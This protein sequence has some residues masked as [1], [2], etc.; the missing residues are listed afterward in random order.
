MAGKAPITLRALS[1][2]TTTEL[3]AL[4]ELLAASYGAT[5]PNWDHCLRTLAPDLFGSRALYLGSYIGAQLVAFNAFLPQQ[6]HTAGGPLPAYQSSFSSTLPSHSGQGHFSAIQEEA[7]ARLRTQA[8]LIIGYP[9]VQSLPIF[10]QRLG[11]GQQP[12][13]Y[14][15]WLWRRHPTARPLVPP[16]AALVTADQEDLLAY[17]QH[18]H[19]TALVEQ[20]GVWGL[21]RQWRRGPLRICYGAVGGMAATASRSALQH[22][23]ARLG[24]PLLRLE[25]LPGHPLASLLHRKKRIPTPFVWRSLNGAIFAARD[26][27]LIQGQQDTF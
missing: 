6:L 7:A 12:F 4:Q 10:T 14:C 27:G 2:H 19:G 21:R 25:Y 11:F 5:L 17:Q 15:S 23:R 24:V 13:H 16:V 26:F 1:L 18:K 8:Q 9:N 20:D 3:L 22:F